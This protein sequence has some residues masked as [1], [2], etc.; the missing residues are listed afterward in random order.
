MEIIARVVASIS[1]VAVAIAGLGLFGM[2]AMA[3]LLIGPNGL[4]L[5]AEGRLIYLATPDRTVMRLESDGTRTVLADG[6]RGRRFNGPNDLTIHSSGAIYVTDSVFGI[7]DG[8]AN[9][10]S[11]LDFSGVYLLEDGRTTL[12]YSNAENPGGWPNGITLSPDESVLYMN[13]GFQNI[14]KYDVLADGTIE[15]GEV[16]IP[17]EGSDGMKVD[18]LGNLYTTSGAGPGEVRITAPDGTRLGVLELPVPNGE[19]QT[20]VCATNVAFGDNDSR[21]LYITACEH[22]YR[23]RMRVTGMH[24]LPRGSGRPPQ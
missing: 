24:P 20:Q 3:V 1:G 10:D 8:L 11:E 2:A 19:P 5:D 4:S 17:G 7:R 13:A 16:F 12:I 22:V 18:S 15:N 14:L 21:T 9:P 23:I 6:W